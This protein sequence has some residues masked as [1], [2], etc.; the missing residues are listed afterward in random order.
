[1]QDCFVFVQHSPRVRSRFQPTD[2]SHVDLRTSIGQDECHCPMLKQCRVHASYHNL[3]YNTISLVKCVTNEILPLAY[4]QPRSDHLHFLK[5]GAD[6]VIEHQAN[7]I[8]LQNVNTGTWEAV[9]G[10]RCMRCC[11]YDS[12]LAMRCSSRKTRAVV[13]RRER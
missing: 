12:K 8:P 2:R 11:M 9:L 7:L 10:M 1:M 3:L 13:M 4:C 6:E 5:S